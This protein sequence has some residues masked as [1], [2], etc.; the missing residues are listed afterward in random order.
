[1]NSFMLYHFNYCPLIWSFC[2]NG[3]QKKLEKINERALRLALSNCTSSYD[4]IKA[5]STTIHIRSIRLL[6]LEMFKTFQNLNAAFMK[7]YFTPKFISYNFRQNSVLCVPKVK[8]TT[9]GIKSLHFWV[10]RYGTLSQM[11]QNHH[12]ISINSKFP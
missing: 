10:Q 3:S 6:A 5:K 8:T 4:T 9:C 7:D 11:K 1:M 12:K 2:S